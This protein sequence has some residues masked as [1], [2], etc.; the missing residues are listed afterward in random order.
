MGKCWRKFI[1]LKL[2]CRGSTFLHLYITHL[3][4]FKTKSFIF[5]DS[6]LRIFRKKYVFLA[7]LILNT[8]LIWFPNF[9]V[10]T[11]PYQRL[12]QISFPTCDW[13]DIWLFGPVIGQTC[14]E[15]SDIASTISCDWSLVC[16]DYELSLF[17][18]L[19]GKFQKDIFSE[20]CLLILRS[21]STSIQLLIRKSFHLE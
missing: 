21:L 9:S 10:V 8:I 4:V 17:I 15:L 6:F 5:H 7:T 18:E 1:P 12:A 20:F 16:S 3:E 14:K 2:D 19:F 11:P 13:S